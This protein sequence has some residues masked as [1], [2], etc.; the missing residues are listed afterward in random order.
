MASAL[1]RRGTNEADVERQA[2]STGIPR[3]A[4]ESAVRELPVYTREELEAK[5]KALDEILDDIAAHAENIKR[6]LK[7]IVERVYDAHKYS[8]PPW[9]VLE[10]YD[11]VKDDIYDKIYNLNDYIDD[12]SF[13]L[14]A[15]ALGLDP[16]YEKWEEIFDRS[17]YSDY[18]VVVGLAVVRE[19]NG[20]HTPVVVI[21]DD[22]G[23][24]FIPVDEL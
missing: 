18:W 16:D 4:I 21:L 22:D 23:L 8:D 6:E 14:V 11:E 17:F 19:E 5:L 12:L 13:K 1:E 9:R 20:E 15:R 2:R 7:A 24:K 10:F 3:E